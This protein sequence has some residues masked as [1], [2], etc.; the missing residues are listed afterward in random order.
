MRDE[1]IIQAQDQERKRAAVIYRQ[2]QFLDSR[3]LAYEKVLGS[4]WNKLKSIFN[5]KWLMKEVE[6]VQFEIL[7]EHDKAINEAAERAKEEKSKP[8]LTIVGANGISK[9]VILF[10]AGVFAS[11]CVSLKKY[12]QME[13]DLVQNQLKTFQELDNCKKVSKAQEN[14]IRAKTDRLKRFNQV[15]EKGNLRKLNMFKGDVDPNGWDGPDGSETW[16]K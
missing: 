1:K 4:T 14:E 8:K 16:L 12:K 13:Y 3:F 6:R 11:G 10:V 7:R 2:L 9:L 5:H 15:D